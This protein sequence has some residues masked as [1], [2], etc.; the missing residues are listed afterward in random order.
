MRIERATAEDRAAVAQIGRQTFR[1][2]FGHLYA[3]EDLALFLDQSHSEEAA[4][5][6]LSAPDAAVWL[7]KDG[8]K[9][10]GYAAA[11]ANTL[12]TDHPTN[13]DGEIARLY[14]LGRYHGGGFGSQLLECAL[15]WLEER[16][17]HLYVSVYADNHG[18]QRLYRR[19]GF[20][21]VKEYRYMVGNHA[22]REFLFARFAD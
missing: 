15:L 16:F 13:A 9:V 3:P 11:R 8:D 7:L 21:M 18:A 1:E 22:D 19:Y 14:V 4:H 20:E 5:K 12:S 6:L 2:T 10:A 17:R